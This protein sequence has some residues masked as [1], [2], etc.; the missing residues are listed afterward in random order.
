MK[1]EFILI[2]LTQNN[3]LTGIPSKAILPIS[4]GNRGVEN[5]GKGVEGKGAGCYWSSISV[6]ESRGTVLKT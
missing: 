3:T 1:K 6:A 5:L 4:K 2:L